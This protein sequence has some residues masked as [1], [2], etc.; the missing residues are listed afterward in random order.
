MS[1]F[2]DQTSVLTP[3]TRLY[4]N[5]KR[6]IASLGTLVRMRR[7][8]IN[9]ARKAAQMKDGTASPTTMLGI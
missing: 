6:T 1:T 8:G 5:R 7:T 9:T 4:P 3:C 2:P